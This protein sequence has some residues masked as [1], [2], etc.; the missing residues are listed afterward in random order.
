MT[1]PQHRVADTSAR[2]SGAASV[3][4]EPEHG[5]DLPVDELFSTR[6]ARTNE[7]TE[8]PMSGAWDSG[9]SASRALPVDD[10]EGT[11]HHY[12][13]EYAAMPGMPGR[14][15]V[16][17]SLLAVGGCAGLNLVLARGI[18]MFFDLC[19]ITVCLVAAMAVRRRDLFT[20]GVLP[21]LMLAAVVAI[22]A[23]TNP[24]VFVQVGGAS[25]AFMAGLAEHSTGLVAGYAAALVTVAGRVSASR[26]H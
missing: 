6:A 7:S 25:K 11:E 4:A 16:L 3:D 24:G 21:P 1:T 22:V 23:L 8:S 2:W 9:S 5:P 18:T 20:T 26:A 12:V 14:G 19:F 15:V 10:V 13:G 17:L